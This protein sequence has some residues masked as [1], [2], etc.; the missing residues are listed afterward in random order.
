MIGV[1]SRYPES[2]ETTNPF[3]LGVVPGVGIVVLNIIIKN[4]EN[5]LQNGSEVSLKQ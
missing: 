4:T 2:Y 3:L 5:R 1:R